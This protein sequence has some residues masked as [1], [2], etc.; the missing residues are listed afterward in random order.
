MLKITTIIIISI[1]I[2]SI[3]F[4]SSICKKYFPNENELS[5]KIV[6]IGIGP[7]I[8]IAWFLGIDKLLALMTSLIVT[9]GLFINYKFRFLSTFEDINRNS[10]G[11]VTYGV[12]MTVLISLFWGENFASLTAGVATMCFGDG[13]AG[14]VGRHLNSPNWMI[15]GQKKSIAGTLTMVIVTGIS[16]SIINVYNGSPL[17][18]L[19]I[20]GITCLG[21]LLE[22]ISI[23]GL[24]NLTVPLGVAFTWNLIA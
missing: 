1:W 20:G 14:L 12:S 6:H 23:K 3:V 10:Y 24:D 21:V 9:I 16:L 18:L 13:F 17:D 11:T 8:P 19:S 5:R 22:Q 2:I 15:F 7:L 4:F